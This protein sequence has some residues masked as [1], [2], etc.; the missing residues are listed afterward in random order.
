MKCPLGVSR[1]LI[2]PILLTSASGGALGLH[3]REQCYEPGG[4]A[5]HQGRLGPVLEPERDT[6]FAESGF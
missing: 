5:P 1:P 2:S 4:A 6:L 3:A